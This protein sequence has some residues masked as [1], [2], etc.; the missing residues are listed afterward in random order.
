MAHYQRQYVVLHS[1]TLEQTLVNALSPDQAAN[2]CGYRMIAECDVR[3]V[4]VG[5]ELEL[6][7]DGQ[8]PLII[9]RA[10]SAA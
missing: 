2:K 4:P 9:R 1:R 6:P 5:Q 3:T 7:F 8:V 10:A